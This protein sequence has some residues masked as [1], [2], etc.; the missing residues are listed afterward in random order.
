[1]RGALLRRL[2]FDSA[3]QCSFAVNRALLQILERATLLD[4]DFV[5]F[6][7]ELL[8][9]SKFRFQGNEARFVVVRDRHEGYFTRSRCQPVGSGASVSLRKASCGPLNLWPHSGVALVWADSSDERDL[10]SK[11]QWMHRAREAWTRWGPRVRA[12][13]RAE[14]R[15]FD[16]RLSLVASGSAW[17]VRYEERPARPLAELLV[18]AAPPDWLVSSGQAP[19]DFDAA[20]AQTSLETAVCF[21]GW[22]VRVGVTRGHLLEVVLSV[23]LDVQG[24]DE[25][26]QI[27]AEIFLERCV[28]DKTLD[29][30]V[31]S[32]DVTR[33]PRRSGLLVFSDASVAT[34]YPIR[35]TPEL[36]ERGVA[37]LQSACVP[38]LLTADFT[39]WTALEVP[40]LSSGLQPDRVFASTV[41]PEALK[42]ALEGM[43]FHS[44]RFTRG[45]E[46]FIWLEW[47]ASARDSR[48]HARDDAEAALTGLAAASVPV[49]LLGSGFGERRDYLDLAVKP[50]PQALR[51]LGQSVAEATCSQVVLGFY[52]SVWSEERLT[53]RPVKRTSR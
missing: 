32:V 16:P 47:T 15:W 23:P 4:D 44:G 41:T 30:W 40:P 17:N 31:A 52:D 35:M 6:G 12:V 37:G 5:Q 20:L 8:L 19:Q 39:G 27:A 10:S 9:V 48:A 53:F 46:I 24:S 51:Q 49:R 26:L 2:F 21:D 42:S 28:G 43:P 11:Q 50:Q 45:D 3:P 22:R 29:D 25:Q 14:L 18:S 36:V 33:S 13:P 34:D 7:E 38:S 1:M